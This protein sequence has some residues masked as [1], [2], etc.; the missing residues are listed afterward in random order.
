MLLENPLNG[1]PCND[2]SKNVE[3]GIYINMENVCEL[4]FV[5]QSGN[6]KLPK[7]KH[8]GGCQVFCMFCILPGLDPEYLFWNCHFSLQKS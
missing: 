1:K 3:S 8:A 6:E 5:K 2:L 4:K 7:V